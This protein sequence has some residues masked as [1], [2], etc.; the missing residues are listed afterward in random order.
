M[1][2]VVVL[3]KIL[4]TYRFVKVLLNNFKTSK[5]L[6]GIMWRRLQIAK[7]RFILPSANYWRA[8]YQQIKP[9]NRF[10]TCFQPCTC[11]PHNAA[12]E[13]TLSEECGSPCPYSRQ[14]HGDPVVFS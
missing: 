1:A 4:Q 14:V 3:K 9:R 7:T 11:S 13:G 12:V 5:V 2:G 6:K 8:T 10:Q